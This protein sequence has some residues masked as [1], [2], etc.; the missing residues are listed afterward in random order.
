MIFVISKSSFAIC[1][2]EA[3]LYKQSS[4]ELIPN[5]KENLHK[6]I[7]KHKSLILLEEASLFTL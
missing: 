7:L 4:S 5:I 3:K 1:F 6:Q 2:K